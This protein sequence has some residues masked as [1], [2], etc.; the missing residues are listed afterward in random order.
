MMLSRVSIVA[1]A[2]LIPLLSPQDRKPILGTQF[3][4]LTLKDA[5]GA[6]LLPLHTPVNEAG[7]HAQVALLKETAQ[8]L[9]KLGF[10]LIAVGDSTRQPPGCKLLRFEGEPNLSKSSALLIDKDRIVRRV[11]SI[12]DE[13][14]SQAIAKEVRQWLDGKETFK[15]QC[16]RCHGDDGRDTSYPGTKSLAGIGN[17]HTESEIVELINRGGFV[18]LSSW[19]DRDKHS[20]ATFVA[21]L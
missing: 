7:C 8:E 1:I 17:R 5:T 20:L 2:L 13:S 16:V 12:P 4:E 18:D 10:Q 14:M 19:K 15:S 9:R 6:V 11:I 21:G 3:P